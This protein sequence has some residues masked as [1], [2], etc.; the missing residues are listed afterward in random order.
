MESLG[1]GIQPW[2]GYVALVVALVGLF[3]AGVKVW[4]G[5]DW[6][7]KDRP[8]KRAV[9]MVSHVPEDGELGL[10][11][12]RIRDIELFR[13]A[14]GIRTS[15]ERASL[16]MRYFETGAFSLRGLEALEYHLEPTGIDKLVLRVGRLEQTGY[17]FNIVGLILLAGIWLFMLLSIQFS[18]LTLAKLMGLVCA[19]LLAAP[20]AWFFVREITRVLIVKRA[21]RRFPEW[22]Q[23]Q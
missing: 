20:F 6:V 23:P 21:L 8:M 16:L 22:A 3:S 14:T 13:L 12:A 5:L 15:P 11:L 10:C 2:A 17:I 18:G 9:E 19:T 4:R 1:G 7:L